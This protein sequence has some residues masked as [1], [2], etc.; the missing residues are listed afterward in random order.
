MPDSSLAGPGAG[1]SW[2][3]FPNKAELTMLG[4]LF[5]VFLLSFLRLG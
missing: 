5:V 1:E 4:G 3:F 2:A